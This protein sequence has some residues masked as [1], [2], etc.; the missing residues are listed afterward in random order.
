MTSS[1]LAG[2]MVTIL[3]CRILVEEE[4]L[5]DLSWE[6]GD[7]FAEHCLDLIP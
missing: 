4:D 1:I 7:Y 3:T 2:K 6:D 5:L